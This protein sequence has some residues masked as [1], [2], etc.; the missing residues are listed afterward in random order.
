MGFHKK[1]GFGGGNKGG[2]FKKDFG[3]A[4][5]G[6]KKQFGGDKFGGRG[7]HDAPTELFSATCANCHKP[8]EVP[9]KP[10]GMKPVYCRDCFG[11]MRDTPQGG[12]KRSFGN[13]EN[14]RDF[15]TRRPAPAFGAHPSKPP[16]DEIKRQIDA[17]HN[18]LDVM[19]KMIEALSQKEEVI[20]EEVSE[21]VKTTKKAAKK[22]KAVK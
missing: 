10:N 18:K 21:P 4:R 12:E 19:M 20:F 9:F 5:F 15:D 17:V 7:G 1:G 14:S 11:A 3:G 13:R 22:S 8:C 2:G 6:G 16:S